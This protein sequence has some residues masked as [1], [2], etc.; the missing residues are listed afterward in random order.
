MQKTTDR[1]HRI[2][3]LPESVSLEFR[4]A[5]DLAGLSHGN[6]FLRLLRQVGDVPLA[7]AEG[8]RAMPL[9]AEERQ[10]QLDFSVAE[11][12]K[13]ELLEM[14][15]IC[16][17]KIGALGRLLLVGRRGRIYETLVGREG[18]GENEPAAVAGNP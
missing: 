18:S 15:R 11:E 14:A 13:G 17:V 8:Q 3:G 10:V 5:A 9:V 2:Y 1:Y 12:I 16:G 6:A 7:V 4:E